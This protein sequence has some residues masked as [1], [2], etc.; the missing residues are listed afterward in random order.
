MQA[1]E[2]ATSPALDSVLTVLSWLVIIFGTIWL[3][4]GVIGYFHRRAYNLTRAESGGSGPVKP[5]FL[6]V[7]RQKREEAIER[8]EAYTE[9]LEE[10]SVNPPEASPGVKKLG[11]VSRTGAL[12]TAAF[13]LIA[14]I[15]GALTRMSSLQAGVEQLSSWDSF[16]SMVREYPVGAVVAVLVIGAHAV[17]FMNKAQARR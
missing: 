15:F 10:R 14:A 13:T 11:T 17:I 5:D 16:A 3:V 8:G 9:V 7:D 2:V 1:T 6:K 4:T 12:I